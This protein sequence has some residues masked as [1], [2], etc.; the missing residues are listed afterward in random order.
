MIRRLARFLTEAEIVE[1]AERA[2]TRQLREL[3]IEATA[4]RW[5]GRAADSPAAGEA[6]RA[7]YEADLRWL[8]LTVARLGALAQ[9]VR[10]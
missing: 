9:E 2:V 10:R 4:A 6:L 1:F 7:F 5:L 3:P 8:D